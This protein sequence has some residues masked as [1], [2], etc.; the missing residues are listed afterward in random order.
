MMRRFIGG[1]ILLATLTGCA[2]L[3]PTPGSQPVPDA[4][5]ATVAWAT[6]L[7]RFVDEDGRVDFA[8]LREDRADLDRYIAFV[9]ATPFD[10]FPEG[11]RRLAHFI[12]AY[13]ALSMHN[14]LDSGIPATNAGWRK[15]RF[16]ALREHLIGGRRLS[17]YR[18]ENDVVRPLGEPRVHFALNCSSVSCPK[19]PRVPFNGDDLDAELE[20]EARRFFGEERNFRIDPAARTVWMS[21]ILDFYR[22]DFV[23]SRAPSLIA[24][25]NR[26]AAVPAPPDFRVR[27][28]AY[29]WT[30]ANSRAVLPSHSR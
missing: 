8:S 29:D 18:F 24:F 6:V 12:N 5:T 1:V 28:N 4:R 25:A 9:A 17:L 10:E 22:S 21:E 16:F 30:I 27:F 20:R 7:D 13:N 14:V 3:V 15:V 19:L 23:P 11:P 2:T 26:Y